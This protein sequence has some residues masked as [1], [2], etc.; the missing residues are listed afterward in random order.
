M[1]TTKL[2]GLV[3]SV[4]SMMLWILFIFYNPYTHE[5]AENDVLLTSFLT[6]F[7]PACVALIGSVIQKPSLLILAFTSIW[8]IRK[9]RFGRK[10]L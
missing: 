9:N 6:L 8:M 10:D 5:R 1:K 2:L 3:A 7:V 4:G